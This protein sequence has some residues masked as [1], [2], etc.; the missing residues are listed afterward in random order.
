MFERR[1][2]INPGPDKDPL[3]SYDDSTTVRL[4]LNEGKFVDA[5]IENDAVYIRTVSLGIPGG[6]MV[7]RPASG[8]M[9]RISIAE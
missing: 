7:L 9:V 8:N 4:W 6:S 3:A 1:I 5:I 2:E